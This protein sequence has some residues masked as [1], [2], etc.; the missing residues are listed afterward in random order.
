M[1]VLSVLHTENIRGMY[2]LK[3][4][5]MGGICRP[6]HLGSCNKLQENGYDRA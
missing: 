1:Y 2:A 3:N 5:K 4:K 6:S